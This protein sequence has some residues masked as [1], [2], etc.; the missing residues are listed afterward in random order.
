[1]KFSSFESSGDDLRQFRSRVTLVVWVMMAFALI[2]GGK[3][4]SM[5]VVFYQYYDR[6][7][8]GNRIRVVPQEGPRGF[9]YDRAGEIVAYNRPAYHVSFMKEDSPAP[10]KTLTLLSKLTNIPFQRIKTRLES[11][12]ETAFRAVRILDN[13]SQDTADIIDS[14]H[15]DIPG[16]TVEVEFKRFYPS[17]NL[18]SHVVGYV[19][20]S[21]GL[22]ENNLRE[23][24]RLSGRVVGQ[25]G[26]EAAYNQQLVGTDGGY[27]V[28]VDH[29]GRDLRVL[30]NPVSAVTGKELRISID[31]KLQRYAHSLLGDEKGVILLSEVKNG[32][33]L[34]MVSSPD[35]DPNLFVRGIDQQEWDDITANDQAAF[36]NRATQGL[37]PPGSTFK[38]VV[39]LAALEEGLINAETVF[40]C[41][42][43]YFIRGRKRYCWYR[44]GHGVVNLRQAIAQSCNVFFYNL[45]AQLKGERMAHYAKLLGFGRTSNLELPDEKKG[46]V[47]DPIWKKDTTGQPWFDGDDLNY[48]IGQGY[49]NVTPIQLLGYIQFFASK[50]V[51]SNLTLLNSDRDIEVQQ[52]DFF[53]S[54]H[55]EIIRQGML[56]AVVQKGTASRANT[57]L[58]EVAGKTGTSQLQG[59]AYRG[60]E[61]ILPHSIFIGYAPATDPILAVVVVVEH[62]EEGGRVAAPFA[63]KMLLYTH[64]HVLPIHDP[65]K[66]SEES[67]FSNQIKKTFSN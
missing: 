48:S 21:S 42:G 52:S 9:I 34:A 22:E 15:S 6:L 7:A 25:S 5:Q 28:E 18:L 66:T 36:I 17:R 24:Q 58:F 63:R 35:Y 10:E 16:V 50:G 3:L 4:F 65:P 14:H 61:K 37:Y 45:G 29:L 20:A 41:P 46:L 53:Q 67:L 60:G 56:D 55:L 64:R 2:W 27:Q 59:R 32:K 62:G 33:I 1:M 12:D 43:H 19:G 51:V 40:N 8:R 11:E 38:M 54:Q 57:S 13:I 44:K 23:N 49:L 30:D 39:A 26:L 47:P 31:A